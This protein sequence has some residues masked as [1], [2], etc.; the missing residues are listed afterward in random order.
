MSCEI[1]T[2]LKRPDEK[3][4]TEKAYENPKFVEDEARD[5][6]SNLQKSNLIKWYKVKVVNKESIHTHD[7]V[8]YICRKLKGKRWVDASKNLRRTSS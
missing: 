2:V 4:V 1:Y 8:S 6:A 7:A 3:Y 5:V